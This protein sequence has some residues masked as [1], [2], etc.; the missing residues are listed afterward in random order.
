MSAPSARVVCISR[1]LGA[2]GEAVGRAVAERLGFGYVDEEIVQRAAEK[3]NV[4]VDL[5]ADAEQ[6]TSLAGRLLRELRTSLAGSSI[7]V[8]PMPPSEVAGA[9]D[10]YRAVIQQVIH[11]TADA[12]DVVIVAHAASFALAGEPGVL[13]LLVTASPETRARRLAADGVDEAKARKQVSES[14]RARGDYLKRFH[15][16]RDE[17]PTSYDLVVNTDTLSTES[18]ARLVLAASENALSSSTG[19]GS[20]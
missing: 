11:E 13:R 16:V 2:G 19:L 17:L 6:R 3:I 5:V 10:D 4:P 7:F 18:A 14:D 9:S 20:P 15:G 8:G 12:G 1:S